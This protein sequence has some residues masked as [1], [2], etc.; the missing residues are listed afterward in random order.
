MP[1]RIIYKTHDS[2]SSLLLI[3]ILLGAACKFRGV[4]TQTS[5]RG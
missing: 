2:Q 1:V 4:M 3:M 5:K